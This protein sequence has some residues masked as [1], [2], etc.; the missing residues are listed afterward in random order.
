[1][2]NTKESGKH[3]HSW[4][5]DGDDP[6]VVCSCGER[7]DALTNRVITSPTKES[8]RLRY[9]YDPPRDASDPRICG[10]CLLHTGSYSG[11]PRWPIQNARTD[12]Y[13]SGGE[14]GEA[15]CGRDVTADHYRW[16]I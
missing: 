3:E 8:G 7:R 6:Y 14:Y 1:M 15:D 4:R 16:P 10:N 5:F 11:H 2:P 9:G 12:T 13:H